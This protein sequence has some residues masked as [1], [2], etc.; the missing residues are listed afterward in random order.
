M[1]A[2]SISFSLSV[3]TLTIIGC[4]FHIRRGLDNLTEHLKGRD[5]V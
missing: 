2:I 4:A 5:D 3:L 1:I